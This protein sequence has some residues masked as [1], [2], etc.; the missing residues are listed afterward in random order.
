M[1]KAR[2]GIARRH[3]PASFRPVR[4]RQRNTLIYLLLGISACIYLFS[5]PSAV[6][7]DNQEVNQHTR[8]QEQ[9]IER[10]DLDD[11][12]QKLVSNAPG[13][14]LS[15]DLL[16]PVEGTGN[17]RLREMGLRVRAFK[18]IFEA[19]EDVHIAHEP[20]GSTF[21]RDDVIQYLRGT[22]RSVDST[23]EDLVESS[24]GSTLRAYEQY[25][26]FLAK[27]T[28]LL[29]P[30]F[31]PY[32]PD[33]LALKSSFSKGGRGIVL[34]AGDG[35]APF[36]LTTIPSFRKLGCTLPIEIM[37][38]GESD[39]SE[40][41]RADL[42]AMPGVITRDIAQMVKDDG[43]KLAGWASKP[44]AILLS[45][46]REV[47]FIDAD[48]AFFQ[49]PEVLLDDPGYQKTGA[50]FFMDRNVM[51]ESKKHWLQEILPKP[52]SRSVRQSRM[53]TG[54]SGHQQESGVIVVDKW[55]HFVALLLVTRM[56]GPDRDGDK[57]K[58]LKGIYEMVHGDKETF[59]LG[60]ELVGDWAYT[61]HPGRIG[62]MGVLEESKQADPEH[63]E[64]RKP[65]ELMK[66]RNSTEKY[67]MCAPQIVH[68]DVDGTLLWFNGWI[69]TDKFG[70]KNYSKF[71][72]YMIEPRETRE[73]PAY[74][75]REANVFCMTS[76]EKHEL[77]S[78][79]TKILDELIER[80][81]EVN[82]E[83]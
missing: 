16:R 4:F 7:I 75:I 29:F 76:E 34:T 68:L 79:D 72:D 25:R 6:D 5:T 24:L 18:A 37:Y 22:T 35:Q 27:F 50:L 42:E 28:E 8:D 69:L 48:S 2:F 38:L 83:K 73:P 10:T 49:N 56:N 54:E 57:S 31:H 45:S 1:E 55:K 44:F 61:F 64:V 23:D 33:L 81:K 11:S 17:E 63:A 30:W 15:R 41:Y 13:E 47:I 26:S 65:H 52:F 46:F 66:F 12:I 19:W 58:E 14:I 67:T 20:D 59:W 62:V 39:L 82:K 32:Y 78:R 21:V 9:W 74:V 51:P 80:A 3:S 43:W 71:Q 36:L 77:K 70:S 60:W 53:W 40:D